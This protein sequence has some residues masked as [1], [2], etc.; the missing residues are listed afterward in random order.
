MQELQQVQP[1]TLSAHLCCVS[2]LAI[3]GPG[4]QAASWQSQF[5]YFTNFGKYIPRAHCLQNQAGEPDWPWII[6]L[7]VLTLGVIV[8][9]LRIVGFWFSS[10]YAIPKQDRNQ[11]LMD[12]AQI[13]IWCAICGYAFS[14]VSFFWPGYRLLAACLVVLNIFTW[15]FISSINAFSVS[16]NAKALERKLEVTLQNQNEELQRLVKE[17]TAE[18]ET[19][20]AAADLASRSK[21]EFLANM[22]HEI[23]TPMAAIVGYADLLAD[24][25]YP[26]FERA[27]A[28]ETVRKNADHLLSIINDILDLSK[29]ESGRLELERV[30]C[31]PV[32]IISEATNLLAERARGKNIS[33]SARFAEPLPQRIQTDPTRLRQIL[34]NI[35]GNAVKFTE[36]G[37][38]TISARMERVHDGRELL[39]I[40]V[41]DTGVGMTTEQI[42]RLFRP[43][44]QADTSITRRFGGTGLGL[45]IC[46]RFA[47]ALG[48]DIAVSSVAKR[49]STFTVTVDPGDVANVPRSIPGNA[50]LV[51]RVAS[52][53]RV[54][55]SNTRLGSVR[56]R[57]LLAEDGPDNQRLIAHHLRRAGMEVRVVDN[58]RAAVD[59]VHEDGSFDLVLMDMSMP[60]MDG[61]TATSLLRSEGYAGAIVALTAHAMSGDRERCLRAGCT[62]YLTKP[63]DPAV[64]RQTC[65]RHIGELSPNLDA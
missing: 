1:E 24:E 34:I 38:V 46:K 65:T 2:D 39:A 22:S 13:F 25:S 37:G 49:G 33:L 56:G 3:S 28:I 15:K 10:H 16:V 44:T 20:R 35:L 6:G 9:Y 60:L 42:G 62:D 23:R 52:Q 58:G 43:F 11:K 47:Q 53:H 12:L 59:A 18:L 30:V 5:D 32:A 7:I 45:T 19:A 36:L 54:S 64:L 14:I 21:S 27:S 57:V 29:V 50:T 48:G 40:S 17:R 55:T 51:Q 61:Y 4:V 41:T 31:D 26:A 63:V 8:G